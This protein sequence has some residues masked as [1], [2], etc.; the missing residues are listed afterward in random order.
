M[1]TAA[2]DQ[3]VHPASV[4]TVTAAALAPRL[5]PT[6]SGLASGLR[7]VV[8]KIAPPMPKATT[9]Q[10]GQHGPRELGLHD[11]EGG[12]GDLLAAQDAEEV[13]DRD[14]VVAQQHAGRER[15]RDGEGQACEQQPATADRRA[16][17]T[18]YDVVAGRLRRLGRQRGV[19]RHGHRAL[20]VR[21]ISARNTGTPTT[22]AMMPTCTSAGGRTTRPAV[23]ASTTR[24]APTSIEK[25]RTRE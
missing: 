20:P 17:G 11:D 23:S 18:A 8:W 21:R 12:A 2:T 24:A 3:P 4:I 13:G 15:G 14:G 5:T 9:D 7:S 1:A 25:G 10:H 6:M 19:E 22:A 16:S